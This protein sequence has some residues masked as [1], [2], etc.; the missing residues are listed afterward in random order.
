[1]PILTLATTG[2]VTPPTLAGVFL[3]IAKV[4]LSTDDPGVPNP[5]Y[6]DISAYVLED[7]ITVTRGRNS[8][9]DQFQAGTGSVVLDNNDGRFDP[10]SV[11]GP[12]ITNRITNPSF[13]IN[14][15]GW[16]A[17]GTGTS[18]LRNAT[19]GVFG[20]S[21]LELIFDGASSFYG[22]TMSVSGLTPGASYVISGYI[23]RVAGV[24]NINIDVAE[25]V[26][27]DTGGIVVV[28]GTGTG[29][30][31]QRF[32]EVFTYPGGGSGTVSIRLFGDGSPVG[33]VRF[34]AIQLEAGSVVT[35]Y[36]DGAQTGA[37]WTGTAH[38]STSTGQ[39]PIYAG[40]R[41]MN[42]I[43]ISAAWN[44][45]S[46]PVMVGYAN[47][48]TPTYPGPFQSRVE[49]QIT[50]AF[51]VL[52][53]PTLNTPSVYSDDLST[54]LLRNGSVEI[55]TTDYD[56][57]AA[58]ISTS[59]ANELFGTQSL[60]LTTTNVANSHVRYDRDSNVTV[61]PGKTYTAS[62]YAAL[63][64]AGSKTFSLHID[65]YNG[66][67]L[68]NT[69][70]QT[71]TLTS[72]DW[73]RMMVSGQAGPLTDRASIILGTT[74]AQGVFDVY[75][76]G[77]QFEVLAA[78][79]VDLP[80]ERSDLRISR[81][82]DA[83]GHPVADR[84][85][86]QGAST[87]LEQTQLT[88]APL[89]PELQLIESSENGRL[90]IDKSG[91]IKFLSRWD[92]GLPPHSVSQATFGQS[93]ADLRYNNVTPSYDTTYIHNEIRLTGTAPDAVEQ[94]ARDGASIGH[95]Y[96]RPLEESGLLV[97]DNTLAD[98][99]QYELDRYG[100]VHLRFITLELE[101]RGDPA[102]QWPV[103]L[104]L[105]LSDRITVKFDPPGG[106]GLITQD[107]FIEGMTCTWTLTN[108][109]I[110]L[111]LSAYGIGYLIYPAGKSFFIIGDPT[112][113]QVTVGNGVL[114][115]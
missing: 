5:T 100:T 91:R 108:W 90:W 112:Y 105:E 64:V 14:T 2:A 102:T 85:L 67:S 26:I 17:F 9:L 82:L 115:Y 66:A 40:L 101:G 87:L 49:L 20:S 79:L 34:D 7:G 71:V 114:V 21:C 52:A 70:S 6:V 23:K 107:C 88:N 61:I 15:T 25:G 50:D 53:I 96:S 3:P 59:T 18:A 113:G 22:V 98:A 103:L 11:T 99:A 104:S 62:L 65:F 83:I 110:T 43:R 57:T 4:E 106:P 31:W 48:W 45:I 13:E 24:G 29:S 92:M 72:T 73:I 60:K 95:Y 38:A 12:T 1:M 41:P 39:G 37:A 78:N 63:A 74:S 42:R 35:S 68:V 30:S 89:L 19:D 111:Q 36:I 86:S 10:T 51:A 16:T 27:I 76:D 81:A 46:Y 44:V 54:N 84:V 32:S 69:V 47:G 56:T 55:D 93:G 77:W 75:T 94:V 8:E 28:S 97:D 58:S 33:S 80:E 109:L